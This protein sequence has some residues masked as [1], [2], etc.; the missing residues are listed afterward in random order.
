MPKLKPHRSVKK[1]ITITKTGK[2][3]RRHAT[4]THFL[5]KKSAARKRKY[6]GVETIS[7]QQAKNLKMKLGV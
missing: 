6:A 4:G 7:G 1:K 5:Q 2:V 3:M